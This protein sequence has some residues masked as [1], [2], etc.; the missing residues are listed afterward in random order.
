MTTR[1]R[2]PK[3]RIRWGRVAA[4]GVATASAVGAIALEMYMIYML[5]TV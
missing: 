5:F 3:L 1:T 2:P 4:L